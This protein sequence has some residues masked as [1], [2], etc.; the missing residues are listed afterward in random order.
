MF[1]PTST[2]KI[3]NVAYYRFRKGAMRRVELQKEGAGNSDLA[4]PPWRGAPK[5]VVVIESWEKSWQ[6]RS[7]HL[8]F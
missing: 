4:S 6:L 7:C 8:F 1:P 3:F 2:M 5:Y